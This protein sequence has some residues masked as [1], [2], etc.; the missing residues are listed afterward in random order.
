MRFG[1]AVKVSYGMLSC[2]VVCLGRPGKAGKVCLGKARQGR[3]VKARQA[4]YGK[5]RQG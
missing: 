3:H 4:R 1:L 2:G 5:A